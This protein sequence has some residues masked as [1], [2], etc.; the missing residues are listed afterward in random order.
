LCL[1]DL[2]DSYDEW[3]PCAGSALTADSESHSLFFASAPTEC[4]CC[5]WCL[6]RCALAV[7]LLFMLG[8]GLAFD[9]CSCYQHVASTGARRRCSA[10]HVQPPTFCIVQSYKSDLQ[11]GFG[12]RPR[13]SF[14]RCRRHGRKAKHD[15]DDV[16]SHSSLSTA[17]DNRSKNSTLND[18]NDAATQSSSSMTS[19]DD[20]TLQWRYYRYPPRLLAV[21]SAAV[22]LGM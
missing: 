15:D 22:Q 5:S 1:T 2:C 4:S 12:S 17:R 19:K 9:R 6:S 11:L 3:S 10:V 7:R 20:G 16:E 8:L 21:Y 13:S 18:S 14:N